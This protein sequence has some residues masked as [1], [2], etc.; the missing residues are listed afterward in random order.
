MARGKHRAT[1]RRRPGVR[2]L[3]VAAAS[4]LLAG[5]S[6]LPATGSAAA[7]VTPVSLPITEVLYNLPDVGP[8]YLPSVGG[9]GESCFETADTGW[10][11]TPDVPAGYLTADTNLTTNIDIMEAPDDAVAVDTLPDPN[12]P[13]PVPDVSVDIT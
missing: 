12:A 2:A 3:Q 13:I 11:C 10:V 5:G 9:G 7:D 8:V 1:P 4:C 6:L